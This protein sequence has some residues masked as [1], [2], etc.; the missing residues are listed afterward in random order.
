MKV[1]LIGGP[2][3]GRDVEFDGARFEIRE[4]VPRVEIN[5]LPCGPYG[6]IWRDPRSGIYERYPATGVAIWRGWK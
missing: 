3:S 2:W 6:Q 4:E 1:H 5:P